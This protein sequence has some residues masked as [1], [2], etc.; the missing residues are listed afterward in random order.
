M[1]TGGQTNAHGALQRVSHESAAATHAPTH[2][3]TAVHADAHLCVLVLAL[4]QVTKHL[5]GQLSQEATTNQVV[6]QRH[7]SSS[8]SSSSCMACTTLARVGLQHDLINV[9]RN[10]DSAAKQVA[11]AQ[12]CMVK[13]T[14]W[15]ADRCRSDGYLLQANNQCCICRY[16]RY[17]GIYASQ[18]PST[19]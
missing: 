3:L 18:S 11:T 19:A 4:L 9:Q 8:S 15:A 5:S 2:L 6:L 14:A 17:G 16:M 13:Q 12:N 1:G 7:N 10:A